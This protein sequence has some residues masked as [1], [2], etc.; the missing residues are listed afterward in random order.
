MI[1]LLV[2]LP[3]LTVIADAVGV[4]GGCLVSA[5]ELGLSV[6]FYTRS[7]LQALAFSDLFSGLGKAFFFAY[8]IGIIACFNGLNV[9]GGADGVGRATTA[10]VVA[11]S[12]TVLVGDFFLSKL[13]LSL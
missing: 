12:V 1:A 11:A 2:M 10:T 6:D 4:A 8:F 9:R 3:L 13:F 5:T 7:L